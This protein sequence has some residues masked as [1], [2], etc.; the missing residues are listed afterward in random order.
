MTKLL[1]DTRTCPNCNANWDAGDIYEVVKS[2]QLYSG[3]GDDQIKNTAYA[4]GWTEENKKQ[5]SRLKNVTQTDGSHLWQC[6]DCEA[7]WSQDT[8]EE[9][10][11][12]DAKLLNKETLH[13]II[14]SKIDEL[15]S[16]E[17]EP[18]SDDEDVSPKERKLYNYIVSCEKDSQIDIL[19]WVLGEIKEL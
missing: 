4:F 10:E 2:N 5:F 17:G 6:P 8:G 3:W 14:Q 18:E 15:N 9:V 19:N 13:D 11:F 1:Q 16:Y 12:T 7:E